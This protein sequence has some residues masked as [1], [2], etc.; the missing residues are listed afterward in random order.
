MG[1]SGP[2]V[3]G[4]S[5][6]AIGHGQLQRR[7]P[8][9][10]SQE[11]RQ[12]GARP[13]PVTVSRA[14]PG[15]LCPQGAASWKRGHEA[16]NS[17]AGQCP[18]SPSCSRGCPRRRLPAHPEGPD[19]GPAGAAASG[20]VL[21]TQFW[22]SSAGS[23]TFRKGRHSWPHTGHGGLSLVGPGGYVSGTLFIVAE[24]PAVPPH[25]LLSSASPRGNEGQ[26][27]SH[28]RPLK[29]ELQAVHGWG[30]WTG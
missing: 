7:S 11:G 30:A 15:G 20:R 21:S 25:V 18:P 16:H 3:A 29:R 12:V 13:G 28:R 14:H 26:A 23:S 22:V 6:R 17:L 4:S 8:G 10:S 27:G 9:M 2:T 24:D 1:C 5:L 19:L